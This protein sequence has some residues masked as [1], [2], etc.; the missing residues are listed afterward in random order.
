LFTEGLLFSVFFLPFLLAPTPF[1]LAY[2]VSLEADLLLD[3]A[4]L[5]CC[6]T[7]SSAI[8]LNLNFLLGA[9]LCLSVLAFFLLAVLFFCVDFD[10]LELFLV[11]F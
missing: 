4:L 2:L 5:F 9:L 7:G 10:L 3:L 8:P 1:F 11:E 6:F